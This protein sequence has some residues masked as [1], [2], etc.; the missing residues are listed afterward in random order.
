MK[1]SLRWKRWLA[2]CLTAVLLLSTMMVASAVSGTVVKTVGETQNTYKVDLT[3]ATSGA[4]YM[5]WAIKGIQ[6]TFPSTLNDADILYVNQVPESTLTASF[7]QFPIDDPTKE[8]TFFVSGGDETTPKMLWYN[9][10]IRGDITSDQR[11]NISDV[12]A[13]LQNNARKAGKIISDPNRKLAADLNSD[14]K[15]N[16]T[17]AVKLMRYRAGRISTLD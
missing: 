10:V 11:I 8:Y 16:V 2:L 3:G 12:V 15:V 14:G 4:Q 5:L 13:I 6:K 1:K 7:P 17:D 9:G